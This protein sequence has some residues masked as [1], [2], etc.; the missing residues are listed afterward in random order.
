MGKQN[1]VQSKSSQTGKID[2]LESTLKEQQQEQFELVRLRNHFYRDSYRRLTF[3]MVG[4]LVIVGM[5]LS[6]VYYLINHQPQPRYFATNIYGGIV[7]LKPLNEPIPDEEVVQWASRAVA[8]ALTFNYIQYQTQLQEAVNVYFTPFGG[9]MYLKAIQ[10]ALLLDNVI[11]NK[12]LLVAEPLS[13]PRIINSTAVNPSPSN[14]E[15]YF[16]EIQVPIQVSFY[17]ASGTGSNFLQMVT[18][19]VVR[20]SY[21]TEEHSE[22]QEV[23]SNNLDQTKGIGINQFLMEPISQRQWKNKQGIST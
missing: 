7:P 19:T 12:Y 21:F 5:C 23:P 10:D 1:D 16:W 22:K 6:I 20:S 11:K 3:I 8:R 17:N 4:M 15:P 2:T 13:A 14:A 18:L 9:K